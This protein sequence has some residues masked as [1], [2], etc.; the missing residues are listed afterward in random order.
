MKTINKYTVLG[1]MLTGLFACND[2]FLERP[3]LDAL[4]NAN[5]WQS[6]EHM[7]SAVNNYSRV[8]YGKDILN[9]FEIAG[10]SA[11]WAVTTAWRTIGGGNY[12]TDI[13]QINNAWI[14]CYS[15]IGQCNFFLNNYQRGVDVS[16]RIRERYAAETIF[17]RTFSYWML[18][19]LFGMSLISP[20]S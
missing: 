5:F 17:Y 15:C 16:E 6:E 1:I 13:S 4:T 20:M 2:G 8:F 10:E 12:A 11:P 7:I 14:R 18:T 3:P 19:S 9:M